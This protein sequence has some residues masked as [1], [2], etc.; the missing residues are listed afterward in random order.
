MNG[1]SLNRKQL[2]YNIT[3][4][5]TVLINTRIEGSMEQNGKS[6]NKNTYA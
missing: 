2:R 6:K 5:E 3:I 4:I 1:I